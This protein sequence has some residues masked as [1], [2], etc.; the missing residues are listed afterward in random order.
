[1]KNVVLIENRLNRMTLLCDKKSLNLKLFEQLKIYS[2]EEIK[3][4]FKEIESKNF[5]RLDDYEIVM[6][7]QSAWSQVQLSSLKGYCKKKNK[8]LVL[9][10]GGV[11]NSHLDVE[12][13][14][15][16]TL[17]VD[18]FYSERL[19]LFLDHFFENGISNLML[20]QYGDKW[21]LNLLM[22]ARNNLSVYLSKNEGVEY[23]YYPKDE[24]DIPKAL[25]SMSEELGLDMEWYENGIKEEA[26]SVLK[27]LKGQLT[28][29]IKREVFSL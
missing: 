24:V 12:Q 16:L 21:K 18:K 8:P 5:D 3:A 29:A 6:T 13:P 4:L 17:D 15:I 19:V 11:S 25:F 14:P 20:L 1:M 7:H 28:K 2:T 23:L 9:F 22:E 27:G 10:S 26:E